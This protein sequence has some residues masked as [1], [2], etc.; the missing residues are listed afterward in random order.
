MNKRQK[1]KQD[2]KELK[3]YEK[4]LRQRRQ[5]IGRQAESWS[6]TG[7]KQRI[8][9]IGESVLKL[10]DDLHKIQAEQEQKKKP[11]VNGTLFWGINEERVQDTD[12]RKGFHYRIFFCVKSAEDYYT[13]EE[14]RKELRETYAKMK[15][16]TEEMYGE[17][18]DDEY[19]E[20]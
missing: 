16:E 8:A 11:L 19:L 17:T 1:I 7:R 13:E 5:E 4:R 14:I 9:A 12:G 10:L 15:A 6:L 2:Q 20:E 3:R 18:T